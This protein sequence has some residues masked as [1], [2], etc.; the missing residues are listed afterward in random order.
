MAEPL[1]DRLTPLLFERRARGWLVGGSVRDRLLGR[2]SPDLDVVVTEDPALIARVLADRL[3]VPFF[4][5]SHDFAAYRVVMPEGH[6]DVAALRG[7]SLEGDL[8]LRDFTVNA[9]ALPLEGGDLIDPHGGVADL[10][11]RLLVPVGP[12]A[13]REDPLRLLRAARFIHVLG[14]KPGRGVA[15][16]IRRQ[17]FLLP[18]AAGERILSELVLTL[19][20]G[21]S[22]G[23][24]RV[25]RE[26]GLLP[27]FLPELAGPAAL[28][29]PHPGT[30]LLGHTAA[31]LERLEDIL[32]RPGK[33]FPGAWEALERRF[34]VEVDGMVPRP[35]AL[36]LAVLLHALGW[37][38]VP[39]EQ[40]EEIAA[41]AEGAK[42]VGVICRRLR[43]SLALT[44]MLERVVRELP[45]LNL[46][47]E[48]SDDGRGSARYLREASPFVPEC[49]LT[50]A[51][52]LLALSPAAPWRKT[53]DE[54]L[55]EWA[56]RESGPVGALPARR[57]PADGRV[58]AGTRSLLGRGVAGGRAC[59]GG[60][61]GHR[62]GGSA[63]AR[64]RLRG[65][66]PGTRPRGI[67]NGPNLN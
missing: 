40:G 36:R 19:N 26:L 31:A 33:W 65:F 46:L 7:G 27:V 52:H 32:E 28:R 22:P 13:F 48:G 5:L 21:R 47:S 39:G 18:E 49:V 58:G 1:L 37:A 20:A 23:A 30:T 57:A 2:P 3:G 11:Q 25:W 12:E 55:I 51:A 15:E 16:E 14:L 42:Q 29:R 34:A 38:A 35:V 4:E 61:R 50:T 10:E 66:P 56:R 6:L 59:L 60:R 24:F 64:P 9:I 63:R 17:A 41:A 54:L 62:P 43:C 44:R 45:A 53:A 8:A 67:I